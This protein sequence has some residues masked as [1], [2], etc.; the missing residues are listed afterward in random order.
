MTLFQILQPAS[1]SFYLPLFLPLPSPQSLTLMFLF[2]KV[3]MN[4]HSYNQV[5]R[6]YNV[7]GRI[8]GAQEPGIL[9]FMSSKHV[10][11]NTQTHIHIFNIYQMCMHT[12]SKNAHEFSI[13]LVYTHTHTHHLHKLKLQCLTHLCS[14]HALT[15]VCVCVCRSVCYIRWSS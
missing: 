10:R 8:R 12:L 5:T 1:S 15:D 13:Y 11:I 6:I 4:V 3:R 7:I 9:Q 14:D 2:S